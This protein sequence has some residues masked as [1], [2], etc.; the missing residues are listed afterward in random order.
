[1]HQSVADQIVNAVKGAA[2]CRLPTLYNTMEMTERVVSSGIE[3]DL[4]ECGVFAG[5]QVA[6]MAL[7]LQHLGV[8]DRKVHLYD[9]F[10]GIPEAGPKD[11]QQP[12]IGPK[13]HG[14]GRL[15]ST[16][17]SVCSAD[18]VRGYMRQWG[19]DESL[20]VYHVGW[21]QDTV[22]PW[23]SKSWNDG[24]IALLRLD[25]DLYESTEVCLKYLY[26]ALQ[27]GGVMIVDDYALP[28]CR[29]AV[30]EYFDKRGDELKVNLV[31][32][33]GG[34]VWVTKE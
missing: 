20:L 5:A 15:V 16:G 25:G 31:E 14:D 34:P 23:G 1:M 4:V 32:G 30:D 28:G 2:L 33:G 24:K 17:I 10:E 27:T 13:K 11:D 18:K 19:V 21:F 29:K 22:P 7:T 8:H 6:V 26:P 12:G 9:S 3:G